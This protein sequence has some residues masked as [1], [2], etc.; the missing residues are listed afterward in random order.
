MSK[1]ETI[2]IPADKFGEM[3]LEM[4]SASEKVLIELSR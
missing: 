3:L 2:E 4:V 1:I